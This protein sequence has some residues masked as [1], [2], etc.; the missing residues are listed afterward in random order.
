MLIPV[1]VLDLLLFQSGSAEIRA[2][3]AFAR[4]PL[5]VKSPDF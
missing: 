3:P 4:S 5:C 1:P 2:P